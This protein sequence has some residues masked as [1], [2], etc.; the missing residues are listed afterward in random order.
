[1]TLFRHQLELMRQHEI[2]E[3]STLGPNLM[4]EPDSQISM[5]TLNQTYESQ[6]RS[7]KTKKQNKT[8]NKQQ[9]K[10]Q[11][12]EKQNNIKNTLKQT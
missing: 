2:L 4:T 11:K 10:Q 5:V 1:M 6:G 3:N 8:K 9:T 7:K 12:K